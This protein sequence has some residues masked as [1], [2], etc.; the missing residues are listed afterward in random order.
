MNH[1]DNK[2]YKPNNYILYNAFGVGFIIAM[3]KKI[4][5]VPRR[6]HGTRARDPC[7]QPEPVEQPVYEDRFDE[8]VIR[9]NTIFEKIKNCRRIRISTPPYKD[10]GFGKV[11]ICVP[12][13]I[14]IW[15]SDVS[16]HLCFLR[17][18]V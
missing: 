7:D 11:I 5:V 14:L 16:S 18:E 12:G 2:V 17:E 15:F 6:S 13:H 1:T 3:S 8:N 9:K 4:I 10:W